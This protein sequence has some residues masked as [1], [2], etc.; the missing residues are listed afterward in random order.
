MYLKVVTDNET[1]Y[2]KCGTEVAVK[3]GDVASEYDY[4]AVLHLMVE[5]SPKS[6]TRRVITLFPDLPTEEIG[7]PPRT[8]VTDGQVY[9][10]DDSGRTVDV[11][12]R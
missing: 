11:I 9:L 1:H 12:Q 3:E 5:K 2:I 6:P 7:V 4:E 8:L 10:L